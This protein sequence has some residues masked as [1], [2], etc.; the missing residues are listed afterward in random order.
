MGVI[1]IGKFQSLVGQRFGRLVVLER[2]GTYVQPCGSKSPTYRCKCDCGNETVVP[3]R[4]L[5]SGNTQSCGCKKHPEYYRHSERLYGVY[6]CI[7]DRCRNPNNENYK[8]YGGRGIDI[9]E[10]WKKDYAYFR[11]WAYENGY[12]ENDN[13]RFTC[14]IDRID[15]NGNYCPENCRWVSSK[16]QGMNRRNNVRF[17]I[18]GVLYSYKELS[19]I[20]NINERTLRGRIHD[21]W[22]IDKAISTP[23]RRQNNT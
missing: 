1:I 8:Y 15:V 11:E 19:E 7:L 3:A 22:S 23:V 14:T 13:N 9:C 20:Y 4:N 16:E 10:E 2:V 6:R 21:G 12:S 5:R 18:D 17:E